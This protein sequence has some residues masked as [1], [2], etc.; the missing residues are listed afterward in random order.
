MGWGRQVLYCV[1]G[2]LGDGWEEK[3]EAYAFFETVAGDDEA[4]FWDDAG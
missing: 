3:R 2:K 1:F 4:F